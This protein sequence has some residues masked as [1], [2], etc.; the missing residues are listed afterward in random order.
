MRLICTGDWHLGNLFHGNDRLPEQR[1]FLSWLLT[2]TQELQPDA[3][4]VAGDVFDNSNPS[5]AAQALYYEFL[6]ELHRSCPSMV[7]VITAGNHDSAARLEAPRTL[8]GSHNVEVRGQIHRHWENDNWVTDYD[9][10]MIPVSDGKGGE[11]VVL[12]VPFL[13][14][15]ILR[16]NDYQEG[17]KDFIAELLRRARELYPGRKLVMMAH[18]YASGAEIAGKDA[19]ERIIV[20]GQEMVNMGGLEE[21]PDYLTCGHIHKRQKIAG[22]P[23]A[24]YSGSVLP[25]SFAEKDYRHGVDLV[26][27]SQDGIEVEQLVYTPAHRLLV[28]PDDDEGL[29]PKKLMKLLDKELSDREAGALDGN[30]DYLAVKVILDRVDKDELKAIEDLIS[31]KNAVLC[32][33]QRVLPNID[34][35]T[36]S[37]DRKMRSVDDILNR[38]PLETLREAFLVRHEHE[39]SDNQKQMLQEIIDGTK[40]EI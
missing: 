26:E 20:G 27:I 6:V 13:R 19:S 23:N 9:D 33:I 11:I 14:N 28:M 37:G 5:A 25:M 3:L 31:R 18:L 1:Q 16:C 2:Q 29:P 38:D 15:D 4:L 12:A 17:V 10:L 39:M 35:S 22:L 30:Y 40:S 32:K 36:I 21:Y 8:L 7:I 24:R 34:I